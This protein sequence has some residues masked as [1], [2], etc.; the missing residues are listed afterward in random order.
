MI[1]KKIAEPC[2]KVDS[3]IPDYVYDY[4]FECS[5]AG[6]WHHW[7]KLLQSQPTLEIKVIC[8]LSLENAL[9]ELL[10]LLTCFHKS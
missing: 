3:P 7:N 9:L 6:K 1:V 2:K 8:L 4:Y 10:F 5:G